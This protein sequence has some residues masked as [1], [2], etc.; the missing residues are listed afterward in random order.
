MSWFKYGVIGVIIGAAVVAGVALLSD[1]AED[2]V[3]DS[4][5][6]SFD[7]LE[8]ELKDRHVVNPEIVP[9]A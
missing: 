8:D 7:E 2:I 1:D 3:S 5:S 4:D 9:E 6:F